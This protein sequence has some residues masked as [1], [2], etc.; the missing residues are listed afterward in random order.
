MNLDGGVLYVNEAPAAF[1]LGERVCRDTFVVH[2]EK[3]VSES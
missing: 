3:A 2:F 1:T